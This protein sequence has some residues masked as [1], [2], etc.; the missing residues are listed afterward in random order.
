MKASILAYGDYMRER[1]AERAVDVLVMIVV[2]LALI[3]GVM[4]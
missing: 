4:L 1:R 2:V 3:V